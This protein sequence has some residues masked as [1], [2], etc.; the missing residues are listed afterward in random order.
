MVGAEVT[1]KE[2][3]AG[4]GRGQNTGS[5]VPVLFLHRDTQEVSE[6]EQNVAVKTVAGRP[7]KF[8]KRP[9]NVLWDRQRPMRRAAALGSISVLWSVPGR[10]FERELWCAGGRN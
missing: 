1:G 2:T 3:H 6:E 8:N 10:M 5:G 9:S 7:V 4:G